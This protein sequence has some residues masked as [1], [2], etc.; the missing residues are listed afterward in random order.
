MHQDAYSPLAKTFHWLVALIVTPMVLGSF[1]LEDLAKPIK[2]TAIMLHKSFGLTVLALMLIRL[3]YIHVHGRPDLPSTVSK[4]ERILAR[5]V[6]YT[7]Y[8]LLIAMPLVGWVMSAAAGH[9]PVFFGLFTFPFPGIQ[10]NKAL[11]DLMFQ[12]HQTIAFI[13]IGLLCL[14]IAG[15]IKHHFC[16]KDA[17]LRRMLPWRS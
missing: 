2:G 13:I 15:A 7:L 3:I 8:L 1:F 11:S 17:V 5:T 4:W 14:H 10:P 12:V 16:D 9:Q 6:Q